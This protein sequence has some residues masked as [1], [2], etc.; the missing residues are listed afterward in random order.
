MSKE[1]IAELNELGAD[2]ALVP[3]ICFVTLG[4]NL[5]GWISANVVSVSCLRKP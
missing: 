3:A 5:S 1:Q 2:G 4:A